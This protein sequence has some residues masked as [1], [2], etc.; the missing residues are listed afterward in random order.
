[1]GFYF[2]IS[3]QNWGYPHI[4]E[5]AE[6]PLISLKNPYFHGVFIQDDSEND[7]YPYS[8]NLPEIPCMAM[9]S[10]YPY[11]IMVCKPDLNDGYPC[12]LQLYNIVGAFE[13]VKTLETV[14]IP[15][16][17]KKIGKKAFSGTCLKKVKISSDC[18]YYPTSFPTDCTI[19]FY[20]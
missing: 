10:P 5:L 17:V 19:E 18:T 13:N 11:G 7:G 3:D 20:E 4:D 14:R 12:I 15:R 9:K 8:K 1:M 6:F 16:T 2:V